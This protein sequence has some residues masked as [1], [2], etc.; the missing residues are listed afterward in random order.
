M[1]YR[2]NYGK[3]RATRTNASRS[4]KKRT[5]TKVTNVTIKL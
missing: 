2:R 3:R 5:A 1:A 4:T